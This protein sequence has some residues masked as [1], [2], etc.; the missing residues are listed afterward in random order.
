MDYMARTHLECDKCGHKFQS[1]AVL[2][3]SKCPK[4]GSRNVKMDHS[5]DPARVPVGN[6]DHPRV[7]EVTVIG[8]N[9]TTAIKLGFGIG[10]G[11][12]V[13]GFV[14]FIIISIF[15]LSLFY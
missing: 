6:S 9:M 4:C 3:A 7:Q 15:G 8:V 10:F 12:A 1:G 11:L 2:F 14:V 13:W 5:V